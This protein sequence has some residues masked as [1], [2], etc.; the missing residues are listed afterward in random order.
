MDLLLSI[1][2]PEVGFCALQKKKKHKDENTL[3][4]T[5]TSMSLIS[6][7][8]VVVAVVEGGPGRGAAGAL[9]RNGDQ[10]AGVRQ[11]VEAAACE[12]LI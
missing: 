2:P 9:A 12:E 3:I 5:L 4:V 10:R 1:Y 7:G 8:T 11:K 6:G